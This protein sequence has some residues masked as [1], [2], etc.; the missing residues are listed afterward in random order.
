MLELSRER[1][2]LT[3][4][5]STIIYNDLKISTRKGYQKLEKR[6]KNI[7]WPGWGVLQHMEE[8]VVQT[9]QMHLE[10]ALSLLPLL[11][12]F[13][14]KE[15]KLVWRAA[16]QNDNYLA[17]EIWKSKKWWSY[18]LACHK[19]QCTGI[20]FPRK[21]WVSTTGDNWETPDSNGIENQ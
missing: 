17:W 10:V 13:S 3:I 19:Y 14:E 11:V 4:K 18:Y 16:E 15:W 6:I 9:L 12:M 7:K 20:F 21:S 1:K 8:Q 2:K 5:E